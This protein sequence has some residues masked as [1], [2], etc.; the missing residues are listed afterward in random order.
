MFAFLQR[1]IHTVFDYCT[2][3]KR[4]QAM[5]KKSKVGGY[6]SGSG[7]P[8]GTG[9]YGEQTYPIRVPVSLRSEIEALIVHKMHP[10]SFSDGTDNLIPFPRSRRMEEPHYS[11]IPLYATRVAAGFP[12]PADDYVEQHL[13]LNEYLIK[14]PSTTFFVR[15]E[16]D[17]MINAGIY[18]NDILVVDR[19]ITPTDGKIVIAVVNGELTVKRLSD[20]P[21]HL[22]LLPENPRYSPIEINEEVEFSIWGV[23]RH[24][25][26]SL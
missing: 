11:P 20:K 7:R 4:D 5:D 18:E 21:G 16:G 6:R 14:R 25:L 1:R 3:I 12:S 2:L 8:K 22:C 19:S 9:K 13:D 26:H 15:V 23:V 24:V 17:S 10:E